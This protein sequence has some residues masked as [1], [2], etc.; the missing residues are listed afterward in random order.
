MGHWETV[1]SIAAFIHFCDVTAVFAPRRMLQNS[2]LF[3]T[4]F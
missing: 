4:D 2:F 3:F 1:F